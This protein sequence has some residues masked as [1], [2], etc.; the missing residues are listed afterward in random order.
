M[1][2]KLHHVAPQK[3]LP[4]GFVAYLRDSQDKN[5]DGC[6][7]FRESDIL[8]GRG[9]FSAIFREAGLQLFWKRKGKRGR[10]AER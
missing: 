9:D 1:V 6:L 10:M 3:P 4:W 7:R 8:S 5:L 2:S